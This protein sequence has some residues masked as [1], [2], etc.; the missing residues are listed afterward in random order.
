M[1]L[2]L[3]QYERIKIKHIIK[4]FQGFFKKKNIFFFFFTGY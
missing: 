3:S 1:I 4:E 2:K